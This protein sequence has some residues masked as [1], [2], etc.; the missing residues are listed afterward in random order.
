MGGFVGFCYFGLNYG[1]GFPDVS[2]LL[3]VLYIQDLYL[4]CLDSEVIL[5]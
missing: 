4:S 1:F 2:Y 5:F 3:F